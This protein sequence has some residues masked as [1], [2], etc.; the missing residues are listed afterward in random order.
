MFPGLVVVD[1]GDSRYSLVSGEYRCVVFG[2]GE[3]ELLLVLGLCGKGSVNMIL[4]SEKF[5][6]CCFLLPFQGLSFPTPFRLPIDS[7][8]SIER[9]YG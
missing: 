5:V 4:F 3:R 8:N 6:L 7:E 1:R 2:E 9:K